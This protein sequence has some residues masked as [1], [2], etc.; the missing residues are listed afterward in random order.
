[1]LCPVTEILIL[2]ITITYTLLRNKMRSYVFTTDYWTK[3]S[4]F[5]VELS[6]RPQVSIGY[7]LINRAGCW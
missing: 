4:R 5:I 7:K 3:K 1:M 6:N 2:I